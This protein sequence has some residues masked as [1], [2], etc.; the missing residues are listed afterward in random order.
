ML[1]IFKKELRSYFISAIGYVYVGIFL[2]IS[3]LVFCY[4]TFQSNS[5]STTSY[6][7]IMIFVLAILL[8]LLTMRLFSE[9]RKTRT[10]QLLLT[11]PITLSSMVLGKFFAALTLFLGTVAVT[12]VNFIP[13][14]LLGKRE[15]A[16]A[17]PELNDIS[18]VAH[19]GPVA[20]EVIGSLI[21][22]ILVG[23]AFVALGVFISALTENQ[24]SAAVITI[25]AIL[26][27]LMLGMLVQITD[28]NGQYIVASYGLRYVLSWLSILSRFTPFTYGYLDI[29]GVLYY[30]SITSIFLFLT[31]RVYD[32]RRWA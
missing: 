1:A 19:I 23:A 12:C 18:K 17:Y 25:S 31:V 9:E 10:E 2:A 11:A 26:G 14:A 22:M 6:F 8:P 32:S 16:A 15:T 13:L 21:G 4:T 27:T 7:T 29:A 28:A 5:Y 30:I 24:L 3:A 20:S